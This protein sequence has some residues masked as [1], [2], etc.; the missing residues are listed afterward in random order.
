MN[1]KRGKID[2]KKL[3]TEVVVVVEAARTSGIGVFPKFILPNVGNFVN[4]SSGITS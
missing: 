1:G 2:S 4:T 3:Q